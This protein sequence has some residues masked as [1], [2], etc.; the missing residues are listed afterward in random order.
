M[1]PPCSNT[2]ADLQPMLAE[3][4]QATVR[5]SNVAGACVE[6]SV[7]GRRSTASFGLV[8]RD[9]TEPM[10]HAS[11][12]PIACN[13]K[14][15]VS[16]VATQMVAAGTLSL[17]A[18]IGEYLHD[19]RRLPSLAGVQVRH[20]LSHST[21][22]L[23]ASSSQLRQFSWRDLLNFLE[24]TPALFEP[25]TVFDYDHSNFVLLG[26]I[27]RRT[28]GR[29][30]VEQLRTLLFEPAG[31]PLTGT[32]DTLDPASPRVETPSSSPGTSDVWAAVGKPWIAAASGITLSAEELISLLD[33]TVLASSDSPWS[34]RA[35]EL[36]ANER[37]IELPPVSVGSLRER[38]PRAWG[39]GCARYE[40]DLLGHTAITRHHTC[41][42]RFSPA[43]RTAVAVNIS[44][45]NP[46]IR[47][48][49]LERVLELLHVYKPSDLE[50]QAPLDVDDADIPGEY[51][52]SSGTIRITR[53][54]DSTYLCR[55]AFVPLTFRR[56]EQ[57]RLAVTGGR[58]FGV[59]ED[60]ITGTTCVMIDLNS[61]RR[62]TF[63]AAAS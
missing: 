38:Q 21:G 62:K 48:L 41:G 33:A 32:E 26:E 8:E 44:S 35:R 45:W 51:V 36:Y 39:L 52:G 50:E 37:I 1:Q 57:S 59:F 20:L 53:R 2:L 54:G 23:G 19:V 12:F 11:R 18:P 49:L 61:F 55:G 24:A 30:P 56:N 14:V 6:V 43:H 10:S 3:I 15:L 4:V 5:G 58:N 31:V 16:L 40:G 34:G 42:F 60:P 47:D 63:D 29:A 25:G 27:L 13:T 46:R 9:S 17:T 28:T 7:A 22:L